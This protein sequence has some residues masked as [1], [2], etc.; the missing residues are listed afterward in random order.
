MEWLTLPGQ[1]LGDVRQGET[2]RALAA[3]LAEDALGLGESRGGRGE[4]ASGG[5]ASSGAVPAGSAPEVFD[6]LLSNEAAEVTE[7][8]CTREAEKLM[9]TLR[10]LTEPGGFHWKPFEMAGLNPVTISTGEDDAKVVGWSSC[11]P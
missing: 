10:R 11:D 9:S 4:V 7:V 3:K 5:S 2:P 6:V 8:D 1:Q